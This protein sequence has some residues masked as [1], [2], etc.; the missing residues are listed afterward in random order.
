MGGNTMDAGQEKEI[1]TLCKRLGQLPMSLKSFDDD[2][3]KEVIKVL[4]QLLALKG[5]ALHKG[6]DLKQLCADLNS[7]WFLEQDDE[8]NWFDARSLHG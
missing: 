3:A 2:R 6:A 7:V 1:Q 5:N 8:G 4:K